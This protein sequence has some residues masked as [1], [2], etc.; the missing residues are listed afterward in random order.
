MTPDGALERS[1]QGERRFGAAVLACASMAT[2]SFS[3]AAQG[4]HVIALA[5]LAAC[6]GGGE[7]P[8]PTGAGSQASSGAVSS[9]GGGASGSLQVRSQA[10]LEALAGCTSIE[11]NLSLSGPLDLR[12]LAQLRR[13]GGTLFLGCDPLAGLEANCTGQAQVS[14]TSLEGLNA[15][16]EAGR[17]QL[18]RLDVTSLAP[19]A[20]LRR[21]GFFSIS[22]SRGF[23]DLAGLGQLTRL[24]QL[25]LLNNADLESLDGLGAGAAATLTSVVLETN[26]A[27]SDISAL[28]G[29]TGLQRVALNGVPVTDLSPL[30]ALESLAELSLGTTALASFDGLQLRHVGRLYVHANALLE[31]VDALG[32]LQSFENITFIDNARLARL[33]EFPS[34]TDVFSFEVFF[35]PALTQGPSF[36]ALKQNRSM[37]IT[38]QGNDALTTIDGLRALEVGGWLTVVENRSLRTLDLRSLVQIDQLRVL[39]N[40]ALSAEA[41]APLGAV[42][43]ELTLPGNSSEVCP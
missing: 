10:E 41:L 36:P 23:R 19:L 32:T 13:V 25:E 30:G 31:Q 5:G 2:S 29:F 17:V 16:E 14:A 9:C 37:S 8:L 11:G 3:G 26:P 40:P 24:E 22:S 38:F 6:G 42:R 18:A 39:C 1:S 43:G 35:N 20:Q 33:P 28:A 27:L 21:V 12:P 15:L 7:D 34:A 4:L